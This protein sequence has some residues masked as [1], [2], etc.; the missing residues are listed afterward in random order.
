MAFFKL[1]V[2]IPGAGKSY[3]ANEVASLDSN[4]VIVSSDDIRQELWG[5]VNDQQNPSAV[6]DEMFIRTVDAMKKGKNVIYDATNLSSKTRKATLERLRKAIGKNFLA[7]CT[8]ITC[9]ISECKRRQNMRERKVPD[10]VIDRMV[11]QFQVPWYNEGW[12]SIY[13]FNYGKKQNIDRE[14][15]RMLGESHD[16]PHHTRSLEM[17]CA[18][19]EVQMKEFFKVVDW[20]DE[21]NSIAQDMLIEAAYHHDIG[22]HKTKAFVDSKGN[23]TNEA[24]YYNHENVG[25]YLWLSSDKIGNWSREMFLFIGLLIQW[26]M[27]PYFLCDAD[28]DYR[29]KFRDW[30]EKHGYGETFYRSICLMHEADKAAH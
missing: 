18:E 29:A 2:G 28:G 7:T 11:R 3:Y 16:N 30:C 14:H 6:F 9:S 15:Q 23:S 8:V 27:Q 21:F 17:H 10:E 12:D 19:C 5:D 26:H 1:L 22:K 13:V 24:H 25:A 4:T 20:N